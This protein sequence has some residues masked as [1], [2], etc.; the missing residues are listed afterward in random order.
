MNKTQRSPLLGHVHPQQGPEIRRARTPVPSSWPR[1]PDTVHLRVSSLPWNNTRAPSL[2]R[3]LW[4]EVKL[5]KKGQVKTL[6]AQ[7]P[8]GATYQVFN[9]ESFS[10]VVTIHCNHCRSKA[11]DQELSPPPVCRL[12]P[13]VRTR[14]PTCSFDTLGPGALLGPRH[15]AQ[16][17]AVRG[18]AHGAPT[19]WD[20]RFCGEETRPPR[21][22]TRERAVTGKHTHKKTRRPNEK[23]CRSSHAGP[24]P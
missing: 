18:Q 22:Q 8:A 11:S 12:L 10:S 1:D 2:A 23:E 4:S 16:D 5:K 6:S 7:G 3:R 17:T 20:W 15:S 9:E 21:Q 19:S 14:S 24:S 13:S